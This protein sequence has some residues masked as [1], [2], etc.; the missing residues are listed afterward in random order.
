MT[1]ASVI[2]LR[3]GAKRPLARQDILGVIDIGSTKMCCLI[4]RN[5]QGSDVEL[6]GASYQLAEGMKAGEIVD[7]EAVEAS[8]LAVVHEAE[9]QAGETL[10]EV[11]IGVTAGRPSSART[12][13]EQDIG[14][15]AVTA[16]DILKAL[17]EAED[18]LREEGVEC[19]HA[20]PLEVTLDGG[21]P[22]KDPRGMMGRKLAVEAHV[23]Q[24][25][26]VP[27]HNLVAAVERCHLEVHGVVANAYAAGLA[28]LSEEEMALGA[29]VLDLGGGITGAARFAAGKLQE[30]LS[31]PLGANHVTQDLAFGLSIGR[32]Q[33]ERLKTLYGSA[34]EHA[35]DSHERIEVPGIGDP[36]AP[37]SQTVTRARLTEIIRPRVEE[38]FHILRDRLGDRMPPLAGRRLVLTGGGSQLEGTI[39]LAEEVFD[40]PTRLGR[41]RPLA[42]KAAF[43]DLTAA[44]TASGLLSWAGRDDGG[45]TYRTP[46]PT[47]AFTA[48]L[49]KLGQWLKENF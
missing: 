9:Q 8:V 33:A 5:R 4:G 10:R 42:G 24:T 25:A 41:A 36:T 31:V 7:V 20:L 38:I 3:P 30:V 44:T 19:L 37:P 23:V 27:L 22:L 21:Q 14:G 17:S 2:P 26:S 32:D 13:V 12:V 11:V 39:E 40:M 18:R 16:N 15:R 47:P 34:L 46:R 1:E 45:L 49:A 6:L 35:G 48:R 28:A 43:D 29:L